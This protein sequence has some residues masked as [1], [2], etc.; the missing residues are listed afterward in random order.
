MVEEQL[1]ARGVRDARVT[2]AM[3]ELPR[4]RFVAP[5][6]A[7]SAYED[8]ALP[9]ADGQTI[10]QPY[11]VGVM[12][13]ALRLQPGHRVLE[14]G[15]GSGY[16]T[17]VLS[18]LAAQVYTV[19]RIPD[20]ARGAQRLLDELGLANIAFRIG[21]GTLGWPEEAP[22]DRILVTAGAPHVP[23][24]LVEQLVDGGR[25]VLPVGLSSTQTLI[26]IDRYGNRTV[27]HALM[28]CRFVPLLGRE[29]WADGARPPTT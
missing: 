27:E 19:E 24:P 29:G 25:L 14:I 7:P 21:D 11:M 18:R 2:A 8:R 9:I 16:Q 15:T 17:A 13:A 26:A 20:L 6:E 3:E 4:E 23:Q 22:F 28:D 5:T 12:T 10:S 1:R